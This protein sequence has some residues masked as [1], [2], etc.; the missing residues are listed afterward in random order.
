MSTAWSEL[1]GLSC[2]R[3]MVDAGGVS[4]RVLEAGSG[5]PLVFLHGIASTLEAHIPAFPGLAEQFRL[6]AYDMPGRGWSDKPD[7]PYTIDYLSDHLVALLDALDIEKASLS[8]QSLGG[9]VAAWTAAY[10]PERV[11]RLIL[12]NPGNVRSRPEMLAKVKESNLRQA[13]NPSL[14][15]ARERLG[16]LFHDK[17]KVTDE[18]VWIRYAAYS[19]PGFARAMENISAI[20]DPEIRKNY[21]WS[22][23]WCSKI[24]AP[25]LLI[26]S[27]H[28]PIASLEDGRV[29]LKWIPEIRLERFSSG[30]FPQHEETE[31]FNRVHLE[32]SKEDK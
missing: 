25:T 11:E 20:L 31:R 5:P 24:Q 9:W 23:E 13:R 30:E 4:T 21:A 18:A 1:F 19:Q 3:R 32:F 8:G 26:W 16:W 12:N 6:V 15:E 28:N 17:S 10:H 29:L 27:E 14:E 2:A 22:E 7:R